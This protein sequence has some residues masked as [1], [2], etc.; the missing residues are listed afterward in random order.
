MVLVVEIDEV[1]INERLIERVFGL[2][3]LDHCLPRRYGIITIET[4][5][6]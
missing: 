3:I 2:K 4:L 6:I 5:Q 1:M